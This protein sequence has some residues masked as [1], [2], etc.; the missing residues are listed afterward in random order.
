MLKKNYSRT[1]R[2]CRVTFDLSPEKGVSGV[3]LCGEFNGWDPVRHP[4]TRRRDGR[5][6]VTLSL[7]AGR[8]YRFR[9]M[10]DDGNWENDW[11]ADGYVPNTFGS[12]DSIVRV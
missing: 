6:S 10:L 9:Y 11:N 8:D 1:G 12:E 5:F 7:E 4:M 2:F 3:C